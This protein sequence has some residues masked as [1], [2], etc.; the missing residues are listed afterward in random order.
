[1]STVWTRSALEIGKGKG[2]EMSF[3]L[4]HAP[5]RLKVLKLLNGGGKSWY[6][7][8]YHHTFNIRTPPKGNRSQFVKRITKLFPQT[9][10]KGLELV[11]GRTTVFSKKQTSV[12]IVN[13]P[14]EAPLVAFRNGWDCGKYNFIIYFKNKTYHRQNVEG[15]VELIQ[16]LIG[17]NNLL[18]LY[19]GST[20]P[21]NVQVVTDRLKGVV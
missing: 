11:W 7:R 6:S 10:W 20:I 12:A 15:T 2:A 8:E 18:P 14:E 16:I 5:E 13:V 21:E 19:M 4:A 17:S 1:M 3:T 9:V